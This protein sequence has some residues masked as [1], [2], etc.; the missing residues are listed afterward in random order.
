MARR[1]TIGVGLGLA[2]GLAAVAVTAHFLAAP[3]ERMPIPPREPAPAEPAEPEPR[4]PGAELP[5]K[6]SRQAVVDPVPDAAKARE[7]PEA[8]D[9]TAAPPR[10][11]GGERPAATPA[12]AESGGSGEEADDPARQADGPAPPS[13]DV[14]R[15]ERDGEALI[16]GRAPPHAEVEVLRDGQPV[17]TARA[18]RRGE[19][20][21]LPEKPIPGGQRQ[22]SLDEFV[23]TDRCKAIA[24]ST[25]ERCRRRAIPGLPYCPRHLDLVG[26]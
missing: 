13:F 23:D 16:A 22:L 19:F 5:E 20:V 8:G 10:D 3:E 17:A 12:A 15:V 6:D 25:S 9:A 26:E 7:T 24:V 18:N 4:E 11:D 2:A 14:V 21:A 1:A